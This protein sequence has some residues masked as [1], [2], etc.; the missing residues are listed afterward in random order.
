MKYSMLHTQTQES[1]YMMLGWDIVQTK[2][3]KCQLCRSVFGL[4]R[5][6]LTPTWIM[7]RMI[8][9]CY[10]SYNPQYYTLERVLVDWSSS[11]M[12]EKAHQCSSRQRKKNLVSFLYIIFITT[13]A[14]ASDIIAVI[15]LLTFNSDLK[16][17]M[18]G[19]YHDFTKIDFFVH[20]INSPTY[21]QHKM[22]CMIK[23]RIL[24]KQ[25]LSILN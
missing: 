15:I 21:P 2:P 1:L 19:R 14:N 20:V 11:W 9:N 4:C 13:L 10:A 5:M 16:R 17:P 3:F 12:L 7:Q 8:Y 6:I 18:F 23:G 22:D 24:M 25:L